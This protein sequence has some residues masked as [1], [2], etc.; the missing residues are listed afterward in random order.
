MYSKFELSVTIEWIYCI[1]KKN[2]VNFALEDSLVL[3]CQNFNYS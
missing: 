3:F 1:A 2:I